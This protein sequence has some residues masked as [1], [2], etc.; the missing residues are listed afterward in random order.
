VERGVEG[1]VESLMNFSLMPD[2]GP[3]TTDPITEEGS[4][5]PYEQ[6]KRTDL[7]AVFAKAMVAAGKAY[8]CFMSSEEL[9]QI[10]KEQQAKKVRPGIYG[11]WAKSRDLTADEIA[12][13]IEAGEAFV[14]RIRAPFPNEGRLV[15]DDAIRGKL[16]MPANDKDQVLIKSDGLPTYH[17]AH[18]V[19]DTLMRIS[20]VLRGDEWIP[21]VA[22][23]VQT[24]EFLGLP[25]PNYAHIA[26]IGK[27]DGSSKRKLSKRKDPE[28]DVTYFAEQGY[29]TRAVLEY[30]LNIANSAFEEWRAEHPDAHFTEY[31]L[32]LDNMGVSLALFDLDK[33]D[34]IGKDV[35]AGYT[36][37]ELY[38][39][40]VAWAADTD[41]DLHAI[42]TADPTYTRRV[43]NVEREGDAPRKDI[44]KLADIREAYG[45]F[46]DELYAA[47]LEATPYSENM[48]DT[49]SDEAVVEIMDRCIEDVR[50]LGTKQEWID[51]MRS[52]ATDNGYARRNKDYKKD[53]DA[54]KGTFGNVMMAYRVALSNK[55]FTPDLYEMITALGEERA[56]ARL[57]RVKAAYGG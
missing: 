21:S 16:E 43:F 11:H 13:R 3:T 32:Q 33:L 29:P 10:R 31:E 7:Y 49:L 57:Q 14:I 30:L 2:E 52:W 5:G 56:V 28:A 46:F 9:D 8:P 26:P 38:E 18:V 35:L 23:H 40:A 15:V 12:E 44:A 4:Y 22:L 36:A 53:P 42:L 45:F 37:E 19:D 48:P 39:A 24:F 17:F 47:S 27:M 1:I 54:Y 51:G 6:S 41:P 25:L 50:T 20:L 55:T 34:S